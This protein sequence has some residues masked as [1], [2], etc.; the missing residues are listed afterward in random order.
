MAGQKSRGFWLR[1]INTFS[2]TAGKMFLLLFYCLTSKFCLFLS[3]KNTKIFDRWRDFISNQSNWWQAR[4]VAASGSA[5][6][7]SSPELQVKYFYY[8]FI[9]WYP[10]FVCFCQKK[11]TKI[12]DRWRDFILFQIKIIGGRL[13]TRCELRPFFGSHELVA[14]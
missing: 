14:G 6:L 13:E 4:K 2:R 10:N 8:Y 7:I 12:S 5:G 3:K 9:V 1:W 11:H